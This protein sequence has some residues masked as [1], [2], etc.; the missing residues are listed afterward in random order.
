M[1]DTK[2]ITIFKQQSSSY[3]WISAVQVQRGWE[4]V[5]SLSIELNTF[6]T[7]RIDIVEVFLVL[8]NKCCR[9]IIDL[10]AV[11]YFPLCN[12]SANEKIR[13]WISS[14][15]LRPVLFRQSLD[16]AW[17]API[18]AFPRICFH[19]IK[20]LDKKGLMRVIVINVKACVQLQL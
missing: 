3:D 13:W 5:T 18:R 19:F 17:W 10:C 6:F 9:D 15:L 1:R 16:E 20:T 14:S 11:A 7:S 4:W 12:R 2:T 8:C